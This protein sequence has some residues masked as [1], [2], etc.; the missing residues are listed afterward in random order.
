[1]FW[2]GQVWWSSLSFSIKMTFL[3]GWQI[4]FIAKVISFP[5]FDLA[6]MMSVFRKDSNVQYCQMCDNGLLIF[7]HIKKTSTFTPS[8]N[9]SGQIWLGFLETKSCFLEKF[10][11]CCTT[12]CD[13]FGFNNIAFFFNLYSKLLHFSRRII[14]FFWIFLN[15]INTIWFFYNVLSL[16]F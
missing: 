9:L 6:A 16:L 4:D 8:K 2:G 14:K 13:T 11:K 12:S 10:S 1:M 7:K 15:N 5:S 3:F